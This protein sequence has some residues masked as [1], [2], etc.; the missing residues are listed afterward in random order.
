MELN[1]G[2]PCYKAWRFSQAYGET[3]TVL[4]DRRA[5]LGGIT[6]CVIFPSAIL[7]AVMNLLMGM[8]QTCFGLLN[9]VVHLNHPT[10]SARFGDFTN[11]L[12]NIFR[13]SFT[14]KQKQVNS[15]CIPNTSSQIQVIK[16]VVSFY[17]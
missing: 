9:S 8:K 5:V 1:L 17:N 4:W 13:F 3:S 12:L 6:V 14:P 16:K 10:S 7:S 2:S 11:A 15:G